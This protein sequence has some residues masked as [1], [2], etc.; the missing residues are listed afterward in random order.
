MAHRCTVLLTIVLGF[1]LSLDAPVQAQDQQYALS[2]YDVRLTLRTDGTIRVEETVR[3]DFQQGAFTFG[4]RTIPQ[5]RIDAL[6][7]VQVTSPDASIMEVT[8]DDDGAA[9]IRW[10]FRERTQP[11][12]FALSYTVAGALEA[13]DGDNVVDW[14][15][16]GDGWTVPIRDIDV[17]VSIPFG[18]IPR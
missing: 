10:T 11:A 1:L 18:E 13:D 12:T 5:G 2:N 7:D 6:Y 8:H 15:A 17:T 9:T 4:T 3:F 16:I 14:Q